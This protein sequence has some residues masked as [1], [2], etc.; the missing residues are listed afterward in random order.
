MSRIYD[1]RRLLRW[2]V[3]PEPLY[4]ATVR[5]K[6]GA[7]LFI[8]FGDRRRVRTVAIC[9]SFSPSCVRCPFRIIYPCPLPLGDAATDHELSGIAENWLQF[10]SA[11]GSVR[12]V[13]L[14]APPPSRHEEE[15]RCPRE[16][17]PPSGTWRARLTG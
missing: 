6:E 7:P 5:E 9:R 11:G 17:S 1:P 14:A 3:I 12:K 16:L 4:K 8:D 2:T 15:E 13:E 10:S